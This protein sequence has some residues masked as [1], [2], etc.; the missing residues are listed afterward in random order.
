MYRKGCNLK[1]SY[2][3]IGF[4]KEN[5]SIIYDLLKNNNFT[6]LEIAPS[7]LFGD[8]PY[9]QNDFAEEH[10]QNI[11]NTY[12]L[13]IPSMQSIW[14]KRGENIFNGT[15]DYNALLRYSY[16]AIDFAKAINCKNLVF[17]CPKNRNMPENANIET[18]ENFI[19]DISNYA[20]DNNCIIGIEANPT[21]YN[22]N[23]IN[24]TK[25]AFDFVKKLN[26]KALKVNLDFGTIINNN[27]NLHSIAENIN[28][29]SHVHISEPFLAKLEKRKEHIELIN[30]L[31]ENNYN[32]FISIETSCQELDIVKNQIEYLNEV[33]K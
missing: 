33:C 13:C 18:F 2:S 27:E 28:Y 20:Y 7:R 11:Y 4:S 14:F 25:Q 24:T 8:T 21:I 30:I 29:I 26:L 22:T 10:I 9:N 3:N 32:N 16:Q 6:G 19:K 23:V 1:L 31:K 12:N 5:D 17:G 15:S